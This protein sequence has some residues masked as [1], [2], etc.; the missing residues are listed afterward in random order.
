MTEQLKQ[1]PKAWEAF[2]EWYVKEMHPLSVDF[3]RRLPFEM[4]QGVLLRFL[5][6]KGIRV[7]IC[8]LWFK[9]IIEPIDYKGKD[10]VTKC[11]DTRPEALQAAFIHAFKILE[12]T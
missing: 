4:Q 2:T 10:V 3:Y 1:Y 9:Y 12:V 5:D 7:G 11:H 8:G 6:E